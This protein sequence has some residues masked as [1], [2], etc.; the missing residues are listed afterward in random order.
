MTLEFNPFWRRDKVV[1][2]EA[3]FWRSGHFL[4]QQTRVL[5]QPSVL[6]IIRTFIYFREKTKIKQKETAKG[7]RCSTY[8]YLK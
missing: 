8:N 7:V 3:I 1:V 5:I 4:H 6:L 2:K